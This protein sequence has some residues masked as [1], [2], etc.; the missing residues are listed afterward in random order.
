MIYWVNKYPSIKGVLY[1]PGTGQSGFNALGEILA[2]KVNPSGKTVDTFVADLTATPT[3]NNFGSTYYTN[4]DDV[5]PSSWGQPVI[6]NYVSYVEGIYVGYKFYETAA[7]E[8]LID[9]D[10][11]VVYGLSYTSFTQ[12]MGQ[13]TEKDGV[14][15]VDVTVT[16][17]GDVAGKDVVEVYF[18]PPYRNGGIEKATAN[19]VA[20]DKTS[21]LAPGKSET[22]TLSWKVEDMAS[23][24]TYGKGCYVLEKGD[25]IISINS[26]SHNIIDSQTYTVKKD[27]VYNE[28]RSTD[29]T[30][31]TNQFG[32]AENTE[33]ITYLSRQDGF[34]N[35]EEATAPR[36][37]KWMR[38]L[39]LQPW[40][41]VCTE[42]SAK[43]RS[44]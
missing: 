20:F 30:P 12:E 39:M 14:L 5:A 16:N 29:Q 19:L 11:T 10:K 36:D 13:I 7:A 22:L 15:S 17:T 33:Q 37:S 24:D 4:M 34:A 1:C 38:G 44:L 2:G 9:Y 3:W 41:L 31:A 42:L 43:E 8:G 21:E 26:D 35:Y 23:Y 32:F 27:I 18:N 40:H 25:Y 6:P 28:G